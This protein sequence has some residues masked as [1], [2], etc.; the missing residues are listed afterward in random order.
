VDRDQS[1]ALNTFWQ[2]W[3]RGPLIQQALSAWGDPRNQYV[4]ANRAGGPRV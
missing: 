1:P 4:V 2:P 3:Q